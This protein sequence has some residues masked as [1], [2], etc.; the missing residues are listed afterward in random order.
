MKTKG[1]ADQ[2]EHLARR[3]AGRD[4]GSGE[5]GGAD[6]G[7]GGRAAAHSRGLQEG[8]TGEL[9]VYALTQDR[10]TREQA[11]EIGANSALDHVYGLN[12]RSY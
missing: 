9:G 2:V 6:A 4:E 3:L 12:D 10:R 5:T 11:G 7:A 1:P 8:D